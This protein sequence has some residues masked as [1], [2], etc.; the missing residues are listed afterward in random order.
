[1]KQLLL[2]AGVIIGGLYFL[3]R[4]K[5]SSSYA[6]SISLTPRLDENKAISYVSSILHIP[7]QVVL[8][9][10]AGAEI[11]A[12]VQRV[13]VLY[14]GTQIGM[15]SPTNA[16][17]RIASN[18]SAVMPS[19]DLPLPLLQLLKAVGGQA[20]Q[21][22]TSGDYDKILDRLQ[23]QMQ[24]VVDSKYHFN[25]VCKRLGECVQLSDGV[26]LIAYSKRKISPL[27]DYSAYIP[28]RTA[29][30]YNDPVLI[31]DGSVEDTVR[32]MLQIVQETS[33]DTERLAKHLAKDNLKDT[34]ESIWTFIY[35]HIA[36]VR[37]S[38]FQEQVRR[39]LR[40]LY[41]Q[42]GDCDCYATLI[43][44]MLYNLGIPFKFRI[45][46]YANKGYYQ[47][48]YVIVPYSGGYFTVDPVLDN[49]NQEKPTTNH[50]DFQL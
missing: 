4:A 14:D 50:K 24:V 27:S 7:V 41:D 46:E 33:G 9:N 10:H 25:V 13:V 22:I 37:D 45:A 47:H 29:L 40:T 15:F 34:L 5:N 19:I 44:S 8:D 3:R 18:K 17:M 43:G 38:V 31:P 6:K 20:K 26:G 48:V 16:V 36:Y 11:V 28:A 21:W 42:K 1:M 30:K 49:F 35:T 12:S 23:L 2:A 39:P 32:L